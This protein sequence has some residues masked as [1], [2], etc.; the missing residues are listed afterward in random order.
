MK[1]IAVGQNLHCSGFAP[2][3]TRSV[4][5]PN[6]QV[7]GPDPRLNV[8][9]KAFEIVGRTMHIE[10]GFVGVLFIEKALRFVI[11]VEAHVELVA[12]GF[13]RQRIFGLPL[14]TV[15]ELADKFFLDGEINGDDVHEFFLKSSDRWMLTNHKIPH[16]NKRVSS[17]GKGS[18]FTQ[19]TQME[20]G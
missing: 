3:V 10:G 19:V 20:G 7:F 17:W 5:D 15:S 2:N 16:E 18:V 13:V 12:V 14:N 1:Q 9:G 4:A 8:G 11:L 6:F